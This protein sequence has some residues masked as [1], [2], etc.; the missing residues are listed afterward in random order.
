[1]CHNRT[2]NNKIEYICYIYLTDSS[3]ENLLD[4][5]KSVSIHHK[6]LRSFAIEMYK[7]HRGISP[8][9]L[10]DLSPLRQADQYNLR[11]RS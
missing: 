4:K 10:N 11:N 9:I 8:D 3:F 2:K 7:V 5:Y 1:M 6:N